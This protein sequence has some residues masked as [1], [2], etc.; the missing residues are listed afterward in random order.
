MK[1]IYQAPFTEIV[2]VMMKP[3]CNNL[4]S[5]AYATSLNDGRYGTTTSIDIGGDVN[6]G[7]GIAPA[8]KGYSF[9][10]WDD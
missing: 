2:H 1:R 3:F 4:F 6:S 8:A 7:S 9:D 10:L 5:S